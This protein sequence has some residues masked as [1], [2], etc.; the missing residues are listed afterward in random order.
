MPSLRI[1]GFNLRAIRNPSVLNGC[2]VY[3]ITDGLAVKVG[4]T[5]GH[6]EERLRDLQTGNSRKLRLLAHSGHL[7]EKQAHA[8]LWRHRVNGEWFATE[9]V[10][11]LVRDWDYL[12]TE[13]W[14]ELCEMV[15]NNKEGQPL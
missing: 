7:T 12:D 13:L 15:S 5:D 4:T 6:P 8:K 10:L 14:T 2:R 9:A 3:A 11:E 1:N